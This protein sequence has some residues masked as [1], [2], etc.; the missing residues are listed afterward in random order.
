MSNSELMLAAISNGLEDDG[1]T[2][3]A[4]DAIREE[5]TCSLLSAVLEVARVWK[6]ARD[7][8]DIVEARRHIAPDSP[9]RAALNR[10]ILAECADV[11]S[12]ASVTL[13]IVEGDRWPI[14]S[15]GEVSISNGATV[16]YL[17]SVGALWVKREASRLMLERERAA[18]RPRSRRAR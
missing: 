2:A 8:R 10:S 5:S 13:I 11:P 4:L 3:A 18:R 9:V 15:H 14:S 1:T 7:S 16:G 6:A 12:G 17:V